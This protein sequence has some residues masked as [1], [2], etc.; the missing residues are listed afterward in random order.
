M[1]AMARISEDLPA[2]LAPTM[3]TISPFGDLQRDVGERLRVAVVEIEVFDSRSIRPRSPRRGSIRAPP[4]RARSPAGA[5]RAITSPWCSTHDV[6]RQRHHRAH[7]VLDQ[8]DGE[9]LARLQVAEHLDHLVALGRPQAGHHLVEQQQLRARRERARDFQPLAVGQGERGG[10]Q[11]ALR[12]EAA[13]ARGCAGA[14]L[15]RA[16]RRCVLCRKRADHH[17]VEHREPG[18]R[19]DDLEGAADAGGAHLVRAQAVDRLP[20]ETISI[21]SRVRTRRRSC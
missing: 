18:E 14:T 12:G 8:Q 4:G 7:H 17:V 20:A 3:A 21:R 9:A 2:P 11:V 5:P 1:P 13:A 19:L 16:R 15:A 6:L 10:G